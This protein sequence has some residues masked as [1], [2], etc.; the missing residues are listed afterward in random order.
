[1]HRKQTI[2]A[3]CK[4]PFIRKAF[5]GRRRTLRQP[6]QDLREA[7]KSQTFPHLD[8]IY[9]AAF[10]FTGNQ[11]AAANLVVATY[12]RAFLRYERFRREYAPE[13]REAQE[14]LDWLYRNLYDVFCEQ[15]IAQAK[16]SGV[17]Y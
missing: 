15:I 5:G 7:F 13:R 17:E 14:T 2:S 11:D 12:T 6:G 8:A 9:S 3:S 1:M 4:L 16:Q 10:C